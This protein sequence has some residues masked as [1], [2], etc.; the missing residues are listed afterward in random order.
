MAAQGRKKSDT[1]SVSLPVRMTRAEKRLL[2]K[3]AKARGIGLSTW[4][5]Q[6]G[7]QAAGGA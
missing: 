2:E 6:L 1:R 3:A 5:R 4:L 7:L